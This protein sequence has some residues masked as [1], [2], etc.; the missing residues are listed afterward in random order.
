MIA[1]NT[2]QLFD[3]KINEISLCNAN[4]KILPAIGCQSGYLVL[5]QTPNTKKKNHRTDPHDKHPGVKWFPS[6]G[7]EDRKCSIDVSSVFQRGS[8]K[9]HIGQPE[10]FI[11]WRW[12]LVSVI[13]GG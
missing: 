3:P 13:W 2:L 10:I 4:K 9:R 5:N 11:N 6:L 7:G 1:S 8:I 12:T